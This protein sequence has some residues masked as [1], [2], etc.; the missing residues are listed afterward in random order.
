[1][2]QAV[3]SLIRFHQRLTLAVVCCL[4]ALG[5]GAAAAADPSVNVAVRQDGEVFIIDATVDAPVPLDIA[6]GVLTDF[7]HMASIVGNLTSSKVSSRDGNTWIVNQEG[8]AK[9]GLLSFSFVS[10]RQI[11]LEPMKRILA[12]NLS[13]TVK[14]ME[15]EANIAAVEQ[16][17]QIRYRAETVPDS[18]LARMFGASFIRHEVRE[19]FL[20]MSREMLKR[21]PRAEPERGAGEAVAR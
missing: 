19:Q 9:F 12:K 10:E 15:S 21:A 13:G 18:V 5:G 14:R 7:D 4:L 17:V 20:A 3:G 6:W 2:Q 8:V 1:M 16:G 11:R